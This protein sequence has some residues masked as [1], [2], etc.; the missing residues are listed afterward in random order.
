MRAQRLDDGVIEAVPDGAHRHGQAG[1]QGA[2]GERL[3]GELRAWS[4]WRTDPWGS[5]LSMA[6]ASALVASD[7]W[8]RES[9]DQPTTR[10]L[11]ASNTTAQ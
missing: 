8:G 6:M 1:V 9:M 10:R 7:A 5:R 3:G 2:L 4:V 11:K